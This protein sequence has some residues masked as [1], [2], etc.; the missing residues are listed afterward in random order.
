MQVGVGGLAAQYLLECGEERPR[1]IAIEADRAPYL[2]Q[3][4]QVGKLHAISNSVE[5]IMAGLSCS[6]VSPLAWEVLWRCADHFVTV[7]D[8]FVASAMRCLTS[9]EL[10]GG[11]IEGPEC[12]AA[13][14]I[15]MI[16]IATDQKL[17][18]EFSPN[19]DSRV[20]LIGSE[21]ATDPEFYH[22]IVTVE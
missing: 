14:L 17:R 13:G 20:L 21:G 10:G 5:T 2:L 8:E 3:S 19:Q 18:D 4:A 22:G 9:S 6:E 1:L 11:N 7:A 12:F 16:A 15:A